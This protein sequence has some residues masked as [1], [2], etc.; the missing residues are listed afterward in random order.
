MLAARI[1]IAI[2]VE[3]R[4]RGEI[5]GPER[6][7]FRNRTPHPTRRDP[8]LDGRGPIT[9]RRIRI[10]DEGAIDVAEIERAFAVGRPRQ[11]A[12]RFTDLPRADRLRGIA[13]NAALHV[14]VQHVG[15]RVVVREARIPQPSVE[16]EFRRGVAVSRRRDLRE[17]FA[18]R[19]VVAREEGREKIAA[20]DVAI[21]GAVAS[22]IAPHGALRAEESPRFDGIAAREFLPR[23]IEDGVRPRARIVVRGIPTRYDARGN[24]VTARTSAAALAHARAAIAARR[25]A[26]VIRSLRATR[27]RGRR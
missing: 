14:A 7:P 5:P 23:G 2:V 15:R 4:E 24:V 10:P 27:R 1:A 11:D 25:S 19:D 18:G 22:T 13:K 16:R 6:L 20:L 3:H 12:D 26:A 8:C 17:Q 21:P 9:E